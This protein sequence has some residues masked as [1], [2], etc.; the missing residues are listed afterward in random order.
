MP[1]EYSKFHD[2][3]YS[4]EPKQDRPSGWIQWKGTD[5]CID[6]HCEC[7]HMDHFDGGFFYYYECSACHKKYAVGQVI[8]LIPL[9]D[10]Q[11]AYVERARGGFDC[12]DE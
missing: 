4:Q 5:A 2:A 3:V 10:E 12:P 11:A 1:D 8:K 6:L 7:G 9:T